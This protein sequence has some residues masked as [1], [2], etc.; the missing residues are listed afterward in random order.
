M[1]PSRK[2][3]SPM[4]RPRRSC[5]TLS[6]SNLE[7]SMTQSAEVPAAIG[8]GEGPRRQ[9]QCRACDASAGGVAEGNQWQQA[10]LTR[11]TSTTTAL[12]KD[13]PD[14]D[15]IHIAREVIAG[16]RGQKDITSKLVE[17]KMKTEPHVKE[18]LNHMQANGWPGRQLL[19]ND[20]ATVNGQKD[21]L[22]D[23]QQ[24]LGSTVKVKA[25]DAAEWS[26]EAETQMQNKKLQRE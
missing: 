22:A 13:E 15:G 11:T 5:G 7:S 12:V 9:V 16:A 8:L 21:F 10:H 2:A 6:G 17:A 20:T 3:H 4:R 24:V 26:V 19:Q 25:V 1:T 18:E 23:S 14:E